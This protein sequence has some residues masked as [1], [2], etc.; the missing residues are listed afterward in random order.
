MNSPEEPTRGKT[1]PGPGIA[2]VHVEAATPEAARQVT[3]TL[4]RVFAITE[5]SET[6]G[7]SDTPGASGVPGESVTRVRLIVDTVRTPGV[8][9]HFRPWLV[10]GGRPRSDVTGLGEQADGRTASALDEA[11]SPD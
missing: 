2:D 5:T 6:T 1:Q 11:D 4:R 8:S 3:E 7:S 10:S 9:E